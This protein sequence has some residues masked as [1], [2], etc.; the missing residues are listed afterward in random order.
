MKQFDHRRGDVF[1]TD[2]AQIYFEIHG[3]RDAAPLLFLHGGMG[4]IEDFNPLLNQLRG[5]YRIIGVDAR[6]HGRST[7][8]NVPLTYEQLEKD[9]SALLDHLAIEDVAIIGFSDGGI[10]GYRVSLHARDRVRALVTVGAPC[11]L[12]AQTR[13]ILMNVTAEGWKEKFLDTFASY[14]DLN[15]EPRFDD[16][17]AASKGMWLD[18]SGYPAEA[19][20]QITCP[21][22]IVRGDDDPL[23]SLAEAVEI[24]TLIKNSKLLNVPFAGH[25]AFAEHA[26]VCA[27]VIDRFLETTRNV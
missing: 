27:K 14:Q 23:F 12:P 6:G 19:I 8:G 22:L 11:T 16:F 2:H 5:N 1:S 26:E 24:R 25:V 7:L 9:A 15:P 17:V 18:D 21:T 13:Q 3:S 10:V 4:T 20:Q